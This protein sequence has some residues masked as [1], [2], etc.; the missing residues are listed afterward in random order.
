MPA[1]A[2][3]LINAGIT[4]GGGFAAA[5]AA[6]YGWKAAL[7]AGLAAVTGNQIGLY[8]TAPTRK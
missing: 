6:G 1:Y 2:I 5:I 3:V 4:F 7:G 8:Q